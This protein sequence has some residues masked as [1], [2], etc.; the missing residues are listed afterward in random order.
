MS[1]DLLCF[2]FTLKQIIKYNKNI[3]CNKILTFK[4]RKWDEYKFNYKNFLILSKYKRYKVLDHYKILLHFFGN[5]YNSY[6][7]KYKNFFDFYRKLKHFYPVKK[8]IRLIH[9]Q[10]LIV[11]FFE[12]KVDFIMLK[13]KFCFSIKL[14]QQNI[15]NNKVLI[16]SQNVVIKQWFM[17]TGDVLKFLCI[18]STYKNFV[19]QSQKWP[20][21]QYTIN[22]NIKELVFLKNLSYNNFGG[23]FPLYLKNLDYD[24]GFIKI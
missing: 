10:N 6:S 4:K 5:R 21:P 1:I 19:L 3:L 23:F 2:K 20:V 16:N 24:C 22:Y 11:K 12:T 9:K 14:A 17:K 8:F 15:F 13:S 7:Y 18:P